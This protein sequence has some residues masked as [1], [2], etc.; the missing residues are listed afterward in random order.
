[1]ILMNSL[2][3]EISFTENFYYLSRDKCILKEKK[4]TVV[5]V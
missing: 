5:S 1:M 4:R 3:L 2:T